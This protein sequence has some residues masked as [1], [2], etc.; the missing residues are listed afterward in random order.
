MNALECEAHQ[1]I[2]APT[3]YFSG[4]TVT[5]QKRNLIDLNTYVIRTSRFFLE[6]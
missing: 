2:S 6:K 3:K 5:V 1:N 4:N